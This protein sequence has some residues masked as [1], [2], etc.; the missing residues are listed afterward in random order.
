MRR[1]ADGMPEEDDSREFHSL[2]YGKGTVAAVAL[3]VLAMILFT[4][5]E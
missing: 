3:I 2:L 5:W 1:E 4:L